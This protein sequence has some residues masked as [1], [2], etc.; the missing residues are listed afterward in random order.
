MTSIVALRCKDGVVIGA[1]SAVTF[2][3]SSGKISTIEQHTSQKLRL[4]GDSMILAGT[5]SVGLMQRYHAALEA[6]FADK[7]FVGIKTGIEFG[8]RLADIGIRDFESTHLSRFDF[9]AFVGF[10]IDGQP[11]LCELDGDTSFQPELKEPSDLWYVSAGIGQ[12]ITDPFLALL[13]EAFWSDAPPSLR[14]GIFTVLW[15]LKHVCKLNAGGIGDPLHISI[16]DGETGVAR[17]LSAE[18]LAEHDNIVQAAMTHLGAFRDILEGR[19][20]VEAVPTAMKQLISA[21][22]S[23]P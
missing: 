8:K 9:S 1:D 11:Y 14:G 20:D 21:A 17:H 7:A 6:A 19:M 15:T 4:I 16:L 3:S 22:S 23:T 2:G 12:T 13:R 18:E 10:A 5:G